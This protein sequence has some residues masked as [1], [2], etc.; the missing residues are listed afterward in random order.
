M[1]RG[2]QGDPVDQGVEEIWVSCIK[3]EAAAPSEVV[4]AYSEISHTALCPP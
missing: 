1:K 4:L 2:N 3:V